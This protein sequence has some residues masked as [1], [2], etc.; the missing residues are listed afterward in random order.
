MNYRQDLWELAASRNGV[1]AV[2]EGEG[3]GVPAVEVRKLAARGALRGHGHASPRAAQAAGV[4]GVGKPTRRGCV[5][6]AAFDR[7]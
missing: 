3:A 2:A 1:V 6:C 7:N 5:V 4:D